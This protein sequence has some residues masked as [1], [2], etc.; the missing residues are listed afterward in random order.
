MRTE[1]NRR[2]WNAV[3]PAHQSHRPGQAAFLR[4]GGLT[5]F[6]EERELLG[7]L[8]GLRLLHLL[9]NAGQDTLSLASLGA[10]A[11]GVD[12]SDEAIGIARQL[13]EDSGIPARF[14]RADV[15]DYLAEAAGAQFDRIYLGYGA[16]C[17]LHDLAGFARG[18]VDILAPGGRLALMEFHPASNMLSPSWRL[19]HGYPQGGALLELDGVGDYVGAAGDGLAPAGFAPGAGGFVNPHPCYLYRW[20]V[21]EVVSAL[22][23]AGL[24]ILTLR[25]YCYVNGER[26]FDAMRPGEGRRMYPPEGAPDVPLMYGLAAE[27]G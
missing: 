8:A 17:W 1:S 26:P 10:A 22:A 21:G 18:V 7:E 6:P 14:V 9:C 23:G 11:T 16:I 24:R 4:A 20:G 5:L 3:A 27:K 25:E 12:I 2:S 19:A 15:Y 13:S